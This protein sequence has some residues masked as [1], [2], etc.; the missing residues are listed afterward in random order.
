[1][2]KTDFFVFLQAQITV[3]IIQKNVLYE[4]MVS[5]DYITNGTTD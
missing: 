3:I 2:W 5:L 1:M 4:N